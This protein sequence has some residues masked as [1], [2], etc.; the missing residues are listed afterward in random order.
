M[1]PQQNIPQHIWRTQ[2]TLKPSLV[3]SYDLWPRNGMGQFKK[4]TDKAGSKQ[5][6]KEG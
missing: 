6:N 5:V 1:H 2:K 4:Q 3:A